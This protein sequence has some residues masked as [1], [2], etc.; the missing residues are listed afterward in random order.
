[1]GQTS[2]N[3]TY[4]AT[5]ITSIHTN[6]NHQQQK[7]NSNVLINTGEINIIQYNN[8]SNEGCDYYVKN[9]TPQCNDQKQK[10]IFD[11]RKLT[12]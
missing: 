8:Q 4:C 6:K 1:M 10:N 3:Q 11:I 2:S 12:N 9:E 7:I 5:N